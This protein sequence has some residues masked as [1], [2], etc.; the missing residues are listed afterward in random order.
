MIYLMNG[1]LKSTQKADKAAVSAA[2][3]MK[4]SYQEI[5]RLRSIK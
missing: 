4:N 5:G 2:I 1:Y 3:D